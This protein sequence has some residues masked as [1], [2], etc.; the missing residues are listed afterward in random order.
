MKKLSISGEFSHVFPRLSYVFLNGF[1]HSFRELYIGDFPASHVEGRFFATN[2]SR[3][4]AS[5]V[6]HE[7]GTTTGVS[8]AIPGLLAGQEEI[9]FIISYEKSSV[10][11]NMTLTTNN[12][13]TDPH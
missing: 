11:N 13:D 6:F 5:P 9:G 2:G 10:M 4:N 1:L 7:K 3:K 12:I 8:S